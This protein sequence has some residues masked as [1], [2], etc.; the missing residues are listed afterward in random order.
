MADEGEAAVSEAARLIRDF[1]NTYEPQVDDERLQTPDDLKQW[2]TDRALAVPGRP[3]APADLNR[4]KQVREGLRSVLL[5]HAGHAANQ[6]AVTEM[7]EALQALPLT[8]R[9]SASTFHLTPP[10]NSSIDAVLTALLTAIHHCETDQTWGRLKACERDTCQWAYYDNSRNQ[11][12]RWCSMA[13]CGNAIKTRRAYQ[14]RKRR[15]QGRPD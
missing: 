1:V 2:L 8:A 11:S 7:N 12:R 3:L 13:G 4:V 10:A 9:F 6:Q 14:T 5:S 15:Q